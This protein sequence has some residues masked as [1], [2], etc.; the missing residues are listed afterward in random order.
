MSLPDVRRRY[1]KRI[2]ENQQLFI[3]DALILKS[4]SDTVQQIVSDK[5]AWS[6]RGRSSVSETERNASELVELLQRSAVEHL[7]TFR[8][9]AYQHSTVA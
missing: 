9:S 5:P 7:T 3:G 2:Y 6:K 1:G 8:S 4:L